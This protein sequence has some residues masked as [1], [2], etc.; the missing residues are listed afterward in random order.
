MMATRTVH[1]PPGSDPVIVLRPPG[2]AFAAAWRSQS[3]FG[4]SDETCQHLVFVCP[5]A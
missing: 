5:G 1:L 3:G 4:E 2:V